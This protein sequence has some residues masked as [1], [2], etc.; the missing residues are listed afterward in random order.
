[1]ND[2]KIIHKKELPNYIRE[3]NLYS[4]KNLI[5]FIDSRIKIK[6]INISDDLS[7][8]IQLIYNKNF[9]KIYNDSKC[10]NLNNAVYKN[11]LINS[12]KKIL[13][14]GGI[15]KKQDKNL[16]FNIKNTLVLTFGNQRDLFINQLNLIDSNYFKF[17]RLIE[18]IN[19]LKLIVKLRKYEY[20][21]FSPG[22]ESFDSFKNYID[23]GNY[24]NRLIKK[25]IS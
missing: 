12:S 13:I 11:N 8:R 16:K 4:I 10:T 9:L 15:L 6:N 3:L 14:L 19:F 21:L 1:M 23:R 5:Y 7:H 17:N 2:E 24:F 18:L 22:G 25:A 20:I